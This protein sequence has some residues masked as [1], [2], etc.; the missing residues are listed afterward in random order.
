VQAFFVGDIGSVVQ[1]SMGGMIIRKVGTEEIEGPQLIIPLLR[2]EIQTEIVWQDKQCLGLRYAGKFDAA[3]IIKTL[4]HKIREPAPGPDTITSDNL[5]SGIME[6]D[7]LSSCIN[8][9]EELEDPDIDPAHLKIYVEEIGDVCRDEA[10]LQ[11]TASEGS[12]GADGSEPAESEDLEALLICEARRA[13]SDPNIEIRDIDFAIA[14]LGLDTVKKISEDFLR[15]K[16]SDRKITLSGF[17]GYES[18]VILK[19]VMFKHLTHFFGFKDEEGKGRLL[20]S[21]E[22]KGIEM[23]MSLSSGDAKKLKEYYISP[24]RVYSEISRIYEKNCFG[25]D[26]LSVN[27]VYFEHNL[28][29]F[30]DLYDGYVLAHLMLNPCYTSGSSMKLTLTRRKLIF[31]FLVYLAVTATKF[32]MDKDRESAFVLVHMLKRA[33]MDEGKGMDFLNEGISESNELL[34]KLGLGANIR[35]SRLPGSSFKIDGY[36]HKSIHCQYLVKS[37][38]DFS[39]LN[40]MKRMAIRYEDDG[41]THFILNKLLI[42]DDVGLNAKA[43]CVIPCKNISGHELYLDE[44]SYFDLVIFKDIDSLPVSHIKEF[45]KLWNSFEGKIITTFSTYSYLDFDNKDLYL[46]L[47][48]HMV[49]FPSYFSDRGI[50]EKMIDHTIDY[51]KPYLG[52]QAIDRKK[53]SGETCSMNYIKSCEL[54]SYVSS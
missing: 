29:R 25:T 44:F 50:Y 21:L 7:L 28:G 53:Y 16:L 43:Y 52:A 35:G 4:I 39:V 49:D 23:L 54:Q 9:M 11:E 17:P 32:V 24:Q 34:K 26:L 6:R 30:E 36:L 41:Y 10:A 8:L 45:V 22:T 42:A 33:G 47:K 12:E 1:V 15:K 51:L 37:F 2:H 38:K 46:L 48:D 13:S 27:K 40:S 18:Y 3:P 5:F 31:S 19:T 20:L 14:R